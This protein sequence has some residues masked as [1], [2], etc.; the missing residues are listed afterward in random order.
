LAEEDTTK[1]EFELI[2]NDEVW[3]ED[4]RPELA[5]IKD[6]V[7]EGFVPLA[8]SKFYHCIGIRILFLIRLNDYMLVP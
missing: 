6:E 5:P 7:E 8:R 3:R 2:I 4:E 1:G